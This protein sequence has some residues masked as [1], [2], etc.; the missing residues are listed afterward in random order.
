MRVSKDDGG[1]DATSQSILI[2]CFQQ[3]QQQQRFTATTTSDDDP[4]PTA[5]ALHGEAVGAG[6]GQ[7]GAQVVQQKP[8]SVSQ[9]LR[10]VQSKGYHFSR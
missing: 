7:R 10:Q 6:P 5:D 4:E 9:T 8:Q 1:R 3:R 2:Q